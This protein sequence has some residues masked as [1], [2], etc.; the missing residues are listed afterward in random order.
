[1]DIASVEVVKGA[2]GSSLYGTQA[3]NGVADARL[4][5]EATAACA[6]LTPQARSGKKP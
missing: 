1:M 6:R 5:R 4:T 3:A 2:A